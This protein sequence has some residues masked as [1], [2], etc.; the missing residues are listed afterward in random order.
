MK[1]QTVYL[2]SLGCAKNTVDSEMMLGLLNKTDFTITDDPAQAEIIIVNTCGFIQ[3]AQEETITAI[4]ELAIYKDPTLGA[5]HSLFAVGCM[6][7]KFGDEMLSALPELDGV[8]GSS[9]Y[10]QIINLVAK[11]TA[12]NMLQNPYLE[13][14]L[15][16][17]TATA[18]IKIAEGCDNN[19]SYCLIPKL[20]GPYRSRPMAEIISEA[21]NLAKRGIKELIL[22][23]QDTTNY[24]HDIYGRNM[25]SKLLTALADLP[26]PWLRIL[27]TYPERIDEELL[28]VMATKPNICHYL[29]MPIQHT[30]DEILAAMNRKGSAKDLQKKIALIR[31]YLPDIALRTTMIVGFPGETEAHIEAMCDFLLENQFDWLGAFAYSAQEDTVAAT[32]PDQIDEAEKE[33]RLDRLLRLAAHI[34]ANRNQRHMGKAIDVLVEADAAEERGEGW[35]RGRSSFQA[36]EIDGVVYFHSPTL[37]NLGEMIK[38]HVTDCEVYDLIGEII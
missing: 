24:G 27:Y 26:F 30:S 18:Y 12:Q 32:L 25:L 37:L 38:I 31:E 16:P 19:C 28:A 35:Y 15:P 5:C 6:A 14:I 34:T 2:L 20:R 33:E 17:N 21:E 13:R 10:T 9:D 4:L 1:K 8:M 36:P 22:I 23:A 11:S 7:E 29:D 3:S